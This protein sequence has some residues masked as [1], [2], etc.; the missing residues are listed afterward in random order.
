MKKLFLLLFISMVL[1]ATVFGQVGERHFES[2]YSICPP[3]SWMVLPYPGQ[4]F[5]TFVEND[6]YPGIMTFVSS[7]Q[8]GSTAEKK[9]KDAQKN[10]IN[11]VPEYKAIST[12]EFVTNKGLKGIKH[13]YTQRAGNYDQRVIAYIFVNP[14]GRS[15]V[16]NC[17]V[18]LKHGNKYDKV[19]D[20]SVATLEINN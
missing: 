18:L 8:P 12:S 13:I 15:V 17:G 19:F 11:V 9:W 20:N 5:K 10:M 4:P 16:I 14:N 2:Y 1:T 6:E 3:D 7:L